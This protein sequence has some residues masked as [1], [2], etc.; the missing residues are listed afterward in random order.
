MK[1]IPVGPS[2]DNIIGPT[3]VL[4]RPDDGFAYRNYIGSSLDNF[5]GS[6]PVPHR[7]DSNVLIGIIRTSLSSENITEPRSHIDQSNI[8]SMTILLIRPESTQC[9]I[10]NK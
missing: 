6:T 5:I 1:N 3:T 7:P 9:N 8:R 4:H 10:T 2:M